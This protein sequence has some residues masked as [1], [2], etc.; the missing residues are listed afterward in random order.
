MPLSRRHWSACEEIIAGASALDGACLTGI[1]HDE[2]CSL[3]EGKIRRLV[4]LDARD[5]H[6]TI[7]RQW[8]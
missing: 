2:A 8:P 4:I 1:Q 6:E 7:P 5:Y 3:D